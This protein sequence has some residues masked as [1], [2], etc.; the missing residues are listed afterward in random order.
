MKKT[1]ESSFIVKIWKALLAWELTDYRFGVRWSD[2]KIKKRG[3]RDK[4]AVNTLASWCQSLLP[5]HEKDH[6]DCFSHGLNC[7]ACKCVV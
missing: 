2:G 6:K 5:F 4:E 3:S 7:E 1:G